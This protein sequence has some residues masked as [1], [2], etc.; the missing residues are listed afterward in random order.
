MRH[1]PLLSAEKT[2]VEAIAEQADLEQLNRVY[3]LFEGHGTFGLFQQLGGKRRSPYRYQFTTTGKTACFRNL[4]EAEKWAKQKLKARSQRRQLDSYATRREVLNSG[5][6]DFIELKQNIFPPS[7]IEVSA[8]DL[9]PALKPFQRAIVARA[10]RQGKFCNGCNTG[11][12]KTLQS[13]VWANVLQQKIDSPA[14]II[15]PLAVSRQTLYEAEKFS[16][17]DVAI[18]TSED[19]IKGNG[20]YITNYQKLNRFNSHNKRIVVLDESSILKNESGKYSNQ[21]IESF[22]NTPFKLACSATFAPNDRTEIGMQAEFLGVMKQSEMEAMF[23]THDGGNTS[24]WRLKKWGQDKFF[25]WM[26]SWAVLIRKPSDVGNFDD[27]DYKL[28]GLNIIDHKISTAIPP[29]D[30]TLFYVPSGKLLEKRRIQKDCLE[31]RCQHVANIVSGLDEQWIVWCNSNDESNV[32]SKKIP[33]AVEVKGSDKESHKINSMLE[34][35][36]GKIQVIV[37]KDSIFGFGINLQNCFNMTVFPNDSY[38]RFYQLVRRC[39]RFGQKNTV[40]VHRVYH[41]LEA[42]ST[43]QN[44]DC[45]SS[46][47]EDLY[48]KL[49]PYQL[50][51]MSKFTGATIRRSTEYSPMQKMI[52]PSWLRSEAK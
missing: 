18:A 43:M 22:Q 8:N 12:G 37:T 10:L 13:L 48:Q 40:N 20:I 23:F 5:Y 24:K 21:I 29:S 46:E 9:H 31:E 7:G 33:G 32:L 19:D 44:I 38:E 34:F 39:Y 17:G 28:P 3:Q 35:Q 27:S 6:Q 25:E 16:I 11:M 15:A 51:Q 49:L 30:K 14:L 1:N 26:A 42:W 41:E 4:D 47:L 45:K 50:K 2:T 36:S 52:I